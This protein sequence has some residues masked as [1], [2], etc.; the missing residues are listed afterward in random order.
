MQNESRRQVLRP[1]AGAKRL[2]L[3]ATAFVILL[4]ALVV[5]LPE[6]YI[7]LMAVLAIGLPLL[8]MVTTDSSSRRIGVILLLAFVPLTG[9]VKA[10]TGNRFAPLTFDIGILLACAFQWIDDLRRTKTRL[11]LLDL[12]LGLFFALAF[13]QMFNSNVPSLQAG[14]EGFRKF[15]FMAIAFYVGRHIVR[16]RDLHLFQALVVSL[17]ILVSVYGIKQFFF[18][19]ALD[20]R[21]IDLATVSSVTILWGGQV[22]PFSTLPGPFHLGLYLVVAIL[23]GIQLLLHKHTKQALRWFVSIALGLQLITLFMTRTKSNWVGL[24]VGIVILVFLQT[25]SLAKSISR[26]IGLTLV[27]ASM[28][29]LSL[30]ISSGTSAKVLQEALWDVSN[31]LGAVTFQYR[32]QL[33]EAVIPAALAKLLTGYGTSS[34]GEGLGNLYE[35]TSSLYFASH[36]LYLKVLLEMG[37]AGLSLFLLIVGKSLN[38]GWK[39]LRKLDPSQG[40]QARLLQ[41]SL[42]V[43]MSFLVAGLAYPVLDAYPVNYYFWLLLGVLSRGIGGNAA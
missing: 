28:I 12:L 11:G 29:A 4:A 10:V 16:A 13:L 17:S 9:V 32:L 8:S 36:D 38:R 20:Y 37:L 24:M 7:I 23:L 18:M 33:W 31:P 39:S 22:R 30:A 6:R 2:Y 35:A 3:I 15:A 14:I 1:G 26:S 40:D 34:A 5:M 41:W 19:S 25:G 42:A 21:M 27:G 43:V